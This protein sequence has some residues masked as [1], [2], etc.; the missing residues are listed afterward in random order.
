[1]TWTSLRLR[2]V[3]VG[4][5]AVVAA[6]SIA[7]VG[8]A[9]LFERHV[10]RRAIAEMSADLDQLAA[11]LERN[12][13]GQL[14]M[15]AAP[16]DP[17]Y[18]QPLSGHYWQVETEEGMLTS[19]S[20]WDTPLV[21]PP[22]AGSSG[23]LNRGR[24]TGPEGE[25]LL[26]VDRR[27][28][29]PIGEGGGSARAAVALDRA[30]LREATRAF[31]RDLAPYM[32]L[33]AVALI[34]GG[35][36]QVAVGLKPLAAVGARVAAVRSG[37]ATRLGDAFPDEVRP[38]AAEVDA[39]I[40]A[41]EAD[42]VGARSRASDLAHGLK[43]PLQALIGE[44]GRLAGRGEAEA[45]DGIEEIVSVMRRHVDRELSRSRIAAAGLVGA[46]D[47]AEVVERVLA[48]LRR[49]PDGGRLDWRVS[50][51][52]GARA[53]VDASDLTEA[54]GAVLENAARHAR[55][56]VDVSVV[57]KDKMLE[58][59]VRDDG[60]GVDASRL[61]EL[62]LRGARLD[63]RGAGLGLAIASGICEAAGGALDLRNAEPG[64]AVTLR[65]R[66]SPPVA[67]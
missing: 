22:E 52:P 64:L 20:L 17:R 32:G 43:T 54:L 14:E 38:L 23:T 53:R 24:L 60:P 48:V 4:G 5:L 40:A 45:A 30:E 66:A 57:Q 18:R 50:V 35:W 1:M 10:E 63:S 28:F 7:A 55:G 65:L 47:V 21:L 2:L 37:A 46:A 67:G 61:A 16:A 12:A 9:L 29:L 58:I 59:G 41:R 56:S 11:G 44:A 39:L 36:A 6:L 49:T 31:L 19:R 13:D 51:P 42:V 25:S 62:T 8:L 34:A 26:V 27:L 33:L 3:L 15:R